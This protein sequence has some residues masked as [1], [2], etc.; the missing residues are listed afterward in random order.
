MGNED[1][2]TW[3]EQLRTDSSS[4]VVLGGFLALVI[5]SNRIED[6]TVPFWNQFAVNVE[7]HD[8]QA[9]RILKLVV[10]NGSCDGVSS[11]MEGDFLDNVAC[12]LHYHS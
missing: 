11:T 4:S 5:R 2:D 7:V 12:S 9:E 3:V 6:N 1:H 8:I 10:Q